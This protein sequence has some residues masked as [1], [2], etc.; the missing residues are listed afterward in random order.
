MKKTLLLF[1]FACLLM[2][3]IAQK[4]APKWL[5][6]QRKAIVQ[7]TTYGTDNQVLHTGTGV[8][9]SETGDVLS[10]YTLFKGASRATVADTDGKQYPVASV[11]GADEL[12]DVI[13]VKAEVPKK[14]PFLS[15]ASEPLANGTAAFLVPYVAGKT[16]SF[17]EGAI[18][19][20]TKLKDAYGYY[21]VNIPLEGTQ[22]DAPL[23]TADGQLFGL[24]QEDAGGKKEHIFAVSAGYINN[25]QMTS[26]NMLSSVYTAINIRKAWPTAMDQAEVML[27][28]LASSQ[29][30]KTY[31]AS[32]NDFIA[33]F[34]HSAVGYQ[35]RASYYA[36]NASE[37]GSSPGEVSAYLQKA[38]ADME[39]SVRQNPEKAE[40]IFA[41][42]KLIYGVAVT[43]TTLT[44]PKWS[45]QAA[46]DM[47][48]EA[49][50]TKDSPVYHQ[51]E[52]DIYVAQGAY[53]KAYDSYMVMND[54]NVATPAS[55]YAAAK[56]K[57]AIPG[58]N[59]FDIINLISLAYEKSK[60][61]PTAETLAYLSERI[62]YRMQV[63]QYA[64]AIA[65]YDEYYYL[66]NGQV[67]DGFFYYR[68]QAKFRNG[69]MPGAMADIKE[70]LKLAPTNPVYLAEE[71]SI[72]IRMESYNEALGVLQQVI[73]Q[74]PEFAACYRL[75]GLCYV[76][77]GKK[78]DGCKAFQKAK[79]LGDPVVDRL[80]KEHCE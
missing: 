28:L 57:E 7:I 25:L 39:A 50:R 36:H 34:P 78:A 53:E 43:D 24:A 60:E 69:D 35:T 40:A 65:D 55:Y 14:V 8:F 5:E 30:K 80:I 38:Q 21:K 4:N 12:Y 79:E 6:K 17:K 33:T 22:V 44:D 23:L 27:Y 1:L 13:K 66:L 67:G 49:L 47:L 20:V 3:A 58:A 73:A 72:L 54:S 15:L 46:M 32:L 59:I 11:A 19:E 2:P 42:A 51:L 45:L 37:L 75:Q 68:E 62:E 77:Q 52:G 29:D 26:A 18:S 16:G 31:L 70:A 41:N 64:E 9:V 61:N 76:R 63:M 71:A 48:Q 74:A 56:V 10:S